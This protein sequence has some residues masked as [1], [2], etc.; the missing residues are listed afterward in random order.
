[1]YVAM[2]VHACMY[3]RARACVCVWGGHVQ[4]HNTSALVET[5][6]LYHGRILQLTER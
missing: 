3:V 4:V 2:R 5:P 1:M 6:L